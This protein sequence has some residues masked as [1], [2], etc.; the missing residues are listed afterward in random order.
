MINE[1]SDTTDIPVE[2]MDLKINHVRKSA[3]ERYE[4]LKLKYEK[5]LGVDKSEMNREERKEWRKEKKSLKKE[6]K[7]AKKEVRKEKRDQ[8]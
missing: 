3:A 1:I 4:A 2:A 8:K 7:T 6:L 5:F